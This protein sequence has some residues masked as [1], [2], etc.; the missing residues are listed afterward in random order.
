MLGVRVVL[1]IVDVADD[2]LRVAD[3]GRVLRETNPG[4]D[5]A[6]ATRAAVASARA[7]VRLEMHRGSGEPPPREPPAQDG[8]TTN[9]SMAPFR[10]RLPL[11]EVC[12]LTA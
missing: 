8:G 4:C 1:R 6:S 9:C 3:V 10:P 11:G 5:A 12:V 2:A 7:P